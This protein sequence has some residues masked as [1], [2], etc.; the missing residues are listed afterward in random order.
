M[1]D[2][3]QQ[4]QASLSCATN[5]D[6]S[7]SNQYSSFHKILYH[8]WDIG[9]DWKSYFS[10]IPLSLTFNP[11]IVKL[12][13]SNNKW[14]LPHSETDSDAAFVR[15]GSPCSHTGLTAVEL[16]WWTDQPSL[17]QLLIRL[18]KTSG[19][20]LWCLSD[21]GLDLH[22]PL[23]IFRLWENPMTH[24]ASYRHPFWFSDESY[25]VKRWKNEFEA[26]AVLCNVKTIH[27]EPIIL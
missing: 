23:S 26:F 27:L 4:A 3:C 24:Q 19:K 11:P 7:C 13:P 15:D 6:T 2:H 1:S 17:L 25:G 9:M 12:D 10:P 14:E 18:S 22:Q 20:R 16:P 8:K 21:A 5:A